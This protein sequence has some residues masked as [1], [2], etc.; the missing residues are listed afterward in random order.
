MILKELI[1]KLRKG[2]V[3]KE[4]LAKIRT[5]YPDLYLAYLIKLRHD[6]DYNMEI[7]VDGPRGV[8][9]SFYSYSVLEKFYRLIR[10]DI[11]TLKKSF[12]A[13]APIN[14]IEER[15]EFE[16]IKCQI[17]E[18]LNDDNV[19]LIVFDEAGD[20][21]FAYDVMKKESK[22]FVKILRKIRKYQKSFIF[23]LPHISELNKAIR[24]RSFNMWIHGLWR[25]K[26]ND[27]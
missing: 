17:E 9:K 10:K 23:V 7:V 11:D 1:Q 8:G 18:A 13:P 4:L 5:T 20:Y 26:M 16:F 15:N 6:N 25:T 12:I 22:Q 2:N 21:L 27:F 19:H 3:S 24:E 14:I